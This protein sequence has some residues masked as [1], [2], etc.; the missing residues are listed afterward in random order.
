MCVHAFDNDSDDGRDDEREIS[1]V[2]NLKPRDGY[3][4]R[5]V[6]KKQIK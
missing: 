3:S 2:K 4:D 6:K 1:Y 5:T